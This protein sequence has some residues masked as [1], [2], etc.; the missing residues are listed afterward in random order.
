M[1][2][3]SGSHSNKPFPMQ[4][5]ISKAL[6]GIASL[7]ILSV[8]LR[9]QLDRTV[10]PIAEPA[11]QPINILDARDAKA[12]PRFEVTAPEAHR[13]RRLAA[14]RGF[15][16]A[17][18]RARVR[19]QTLPPLTGAKR[20]WRITNDGDVAALEAAADRIWNEIAA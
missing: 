20:H 7:A 15:D 14:A 6:L 2:P 3:V 18:A 16:D 11:V 1:S 12:P 17:E 4:I 10:L 8:P 9:A 19:G 13:V 5:P